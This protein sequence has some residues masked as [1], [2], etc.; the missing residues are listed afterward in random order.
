M[1]DVSLRWVKHLGLCVILTG[2]TTAAANTGSSQGAERV[3]TTQQDLS[4]S[5]SHLAVSTEFMDLDFLPAGVAAGRFVVFIGD[6]LDG[7]VFAYN[8]FTGRQIGELPQP[9]GGFAV[10][11]IMH[12]MGEGRVGVMGAGGLPQLNPFVPAAPLIY[13]YAYSFN[14]PSTF[15]ASLTNIVDFSSVVIGFPEDFVQ[16]PDG[17][18]LLTDSVIGSIWV[19]QTDGTI[20]PGITPQTFDL[21]NGIPVLTFCPTMPEVLVNGVPFLFTGSTIPGV[22]SIAVRNGTVYFST[23]CARGV[24]K[25][26]LSILSDHRQPFQRAADI[27]LLSP[28][29]SDTTIEEL[30]DF[31]FNAFDPDDAHLY[32]AHGMQLEIT[33]IDTATGVRQVVAHDPRLFDFPSSLAFLP[34]LFGGFEQGISSMLVVSNQQERTPI[35]NDAAT[36]NSFVLPF[37]VTKVSMLP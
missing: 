25:F 14:L 22:E 32:A 1:R 6:P 37:I 21:H 27:T 12:A 33:R 18:I 4:V 11:F 19:A 17:R 5:V 29:P 23:A 13:E 31:Q 16:T 2:C 28:T 34:P 24:Y 9:P 30:L 7:R 15:S 8:R 20:T 35:T 26:P 10:P 36:M 3:A